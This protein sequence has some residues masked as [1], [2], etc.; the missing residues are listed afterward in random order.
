LSR[1]KIATRHR[2]TT[3]DGK[4]IGIGKRRHKSDVETIFRIGVYSADNK[5]LNQ[6]CKKQFTD[7][8]EAQNWLDDYADAAGFRIVNTYKAKGY[9][10]A[11][12]LVCPMCGRRFDKRE[13]RK[14]AC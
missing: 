7:E 8:Q 3:D 6:Y 13:G 2:Y 9:I 5:W 11:D 1:T 12:A 10:P 14:R 4:V